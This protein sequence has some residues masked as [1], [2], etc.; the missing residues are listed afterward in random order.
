MSAGVNNN[1]ISHK[2]RKYI[3]NQK[4]SLPLTTFNYSDGLQAQGFWI[5]VAKKLTNQPTYML[6]VDKL[7]SSL[8]YVYES[9]PGNSQLKIKKLFPLEM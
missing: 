9:T 5:H 1:K 7:G 4:F 8:Y 3:N 2:G 6:L